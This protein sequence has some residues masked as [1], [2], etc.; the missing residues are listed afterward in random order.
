MTQFVEKE[1]KTKE[2]KM[3]RPRLGLVILAQ[4]V[5]H[6]IP[7]HDGVRSARKEAAEIGERLS[8]Y[9]FPPRVAAERVL[10]TILF[11]G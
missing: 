5:L 3:G 1:R 2:E 10:L 11:S 4:G 6:L 7:L 8:S 9:H